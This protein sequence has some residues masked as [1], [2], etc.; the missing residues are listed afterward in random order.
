MV[1][2]VS[3][4]GLTIAVQPAASAGPSLRV[5]I[6]AGKFHGVTSTEMPTGWGSTSTRAAPPGAIA[7]SPSART[8]SSANQRRNSA[9]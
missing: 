6:A 1:S 2:G 8:A 4:A 5:A 9:A 7:Y 3:V